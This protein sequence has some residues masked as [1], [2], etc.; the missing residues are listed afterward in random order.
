V[1]N[2]FWGDFARRIFGV[3]REEFSGVT[4]SRGFGPFLGGFGRTD[5]KRDFVKTEKKVK[6]K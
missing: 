5:T 1:K 6:K 3:S 2:G 4:R